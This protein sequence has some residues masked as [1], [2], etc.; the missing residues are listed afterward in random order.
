MTVYLDYYEQTFEAAKGFDDDFDFC[1]SLSPSEAT[2]RDPKD[3]KN[4]HPQ[5]ETAPPSPPPAR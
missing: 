1:P 3:K 4:T 2:A 5:L